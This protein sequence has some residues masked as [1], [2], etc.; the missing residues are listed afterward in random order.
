MKFLC[1][2][3]SIVFEIMNNEWM[4]TAS[5]SVP[6]NF[7]MATI[8]VEGFFDVNIEFFFGTLANF[9]GSKTCVH[10]KRVLKIEKNKF[11]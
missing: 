10:P 3:I 9:R 2:S 1:K 5:I 4:S 6:A 7:L 8:L 11:H